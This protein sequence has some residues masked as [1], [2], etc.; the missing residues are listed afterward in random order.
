M[1]K[2]AY[3]K[4]A[5]RVVFLKQGC[6]LLIGSPLSSTNSSLPSEDQILIEGT[7]SGS[8]FWGR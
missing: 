4:P 3:L 8:G 6:L 1:K 7:P 2:R 5:M